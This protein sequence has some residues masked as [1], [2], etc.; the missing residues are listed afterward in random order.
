MTESEVLFMKKQIQ[1][2]VFLIMTGLLV[3][4]IPEITVSAVEKESIKASM[5]SS[6]D[7]YGVA[8]NLPDDIKE[9]DS[10]WWNFSELNINVCV[11]NEFTGLTS[12]SFGVTV[13]LPDQGLCDGEYGIEVNFNPM[14]NSF[15][16]IGIVDCRFSVSDGKISSGNAVKVN[17]GYQLI[18]SGSYASKDTSDND[19]VFQVKTHNSHANKHTQII[20]SNYYFADGV[21]GI[22]VPRVTEAEIQGIRFNYTTHKRSDYQVAVKRTG[23]EL[24]VDEFPLKLYPG[25]TKT[26]KAASDLYSKLNLTYS[27]SD[28]TIATISK[29]GKIS[30]V[31]AG[32]TTITVKDKNSGAAFSWTLEVINPYLSFRSEKVSMPLGSSFTFEAEGN[33]YKAGKI[34]WSSS[35]KKVG[36]I[37]ANG[38][39]ATRGAGKTKITA[40][41]KENERKC[42]VT[43]E[44]YEVKNQKLSE[45]INITPH[46]EVPDEIES[47][48]E[49]HI[50]AVYE[51]VY[52][53][54]NYGV[55]EEFTLGFKHI[56]GAPA[57]TT[58]VDGKTLMFFDID[59][60]KNNTQDIDCVTHELIHC[61]QSYG[62]STK[63][64]EDRV[65]LGE[66]LTDYGRYLFGLKN[67]EIGWTLGKYAAGQNYTDSYTVTAAFIKYVVEEHNKN[68]ATLLN[69]A[70]TEGVYTEQLWKDTTGY[71]IDELWE[72]YKNY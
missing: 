48:I 10:D 5:V 23:S 33:G 28:K 17:G 11:K 61:A 50:Y 20:L 8:V 4:F 55:Y 32:R 70:L 60:I 2:L 69:D 63:T 59:Y 41:D 47:A 27:S 44:V 40:N 24:Y 72:L 14:P 49:K 53:F 65:W 30:A 38:L 3:G 26:I 68:F 66:G 25:E 56:D 71:T 13:F 46:D 12:G 51:D 9:G 7:E 22:Q 15:Y 42:S 1:C 21:Y 37:D 57:Y 54:F 39:F 45:Y 29:K 67:K 43:V 34:S 36:T 35:D 6:F 31:K 18:L 19:I 58:W 16:G 64:G 62:F 52:E